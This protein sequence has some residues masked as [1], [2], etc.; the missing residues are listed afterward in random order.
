MVFWRELQVQQFLQRAYPS[1]VTR[2][3]REVVTCFVTQ[4]GRAVASQRKM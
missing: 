2:Y 1:G 3:V 4:K